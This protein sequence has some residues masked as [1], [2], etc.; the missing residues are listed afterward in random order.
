M[1]LQSCQQ[2]RTAYLMS[3]T[4]LTTTLGWDAF[5]SATSYRKSLKSQITASALCQPF[6]TPAGFGTFR[7]INSDQLSLSLDAIKISNST[8]INLL[9][10]AGKFS[11]SDDVKQHK[12]QPRSTETNKHRHT[13]NILFNK[14]VAPQ[15][16][17]SYFTNSFRAVLTNTDKETHL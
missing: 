16:L 10:W 3:M 13:D 6:F 9:I 12:Q 1:L 14:L 15:I 4:W 5:P 7:K 8:K 2:H 11:F 17:F